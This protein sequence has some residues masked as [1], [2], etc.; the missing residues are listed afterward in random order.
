M[1]AERDRTMTIETIARRKGFSRTRRLSSP[2]IGK[3]IREAV[4][5]KDGTN[6]VSIKR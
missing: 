5:D 2:R 3:R 1:T 4:R 6:G